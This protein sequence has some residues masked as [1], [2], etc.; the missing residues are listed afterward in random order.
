MATSTLRGQ[1]TSVVNKATPSRLEPQQ[2]EYEAYFYPHTI[3]FSSF[4]R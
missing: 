2:K 3:F 4:I 1:W